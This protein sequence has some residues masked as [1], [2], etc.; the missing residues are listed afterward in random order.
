MCKTRQVALFVNAAT[1][2]DR[3]IIRGVSDYAG[4]V[5][6]WTLYIE[7][8]PLRRLPELRVWP[9]DGAI[10]NFHS[11]KVAMVAKGLKTP[12]VRTGGGYGWGDPALANVYFEPDNEAIARLAAEHLIDRGFTRLAFCSLSRS[13]I[14]PWPKD[15]LAWPEE[16]AQAFK[17]RASEA[18]LPC[19]VYTGRHSA[20]RRWAE[21]QHELCGWLDSLEKPVGLMACNDAR[22]LHVL[23]ACRNMGLRVPDDI[24]VIGVDNDEMLCELSNPPLSSVDQAARRLGYQ[25]AA[26]LDRLM[27]G[28]KA[29]QL[30]FIVPPE[31]VV[32]R[33]STDSLVIE[34]AEVAAVVRF[35]REHACNRIQVP[36]VVKMVD[37][38]RSTLRTRFKAVMGRTIHA[39]IQRVQI[40]HARQLVVTSSLPL[41]QIAVRAGFRHVQYMTTLFRQHFGQTPAEYRKRSRPWGI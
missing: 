11:R 39:E 26:M 7:E 5:G 21:L 34:D 33:R 30:R 10:A 28:K 29:P 19:S 27:S 35:I 37:V 4:E 15:R 8:D 14:A 23:A 12:L 16:R 40:E 9:F 36:D 17:R 25:A 13:Q 24:A 31:G 32:T 2:Y 20:A 6:G 3:K 38:S 41:K 18:G 22:A 1:P